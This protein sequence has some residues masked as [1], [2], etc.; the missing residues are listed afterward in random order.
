MKPDSLHRDLIPQAAD[1]AACPAGQAATVHPSVH[2]SYCALPIGK[3]LA[4][5]SWRA[6]S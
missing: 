5:A 6:I 4:T 3:L 2:S 1:S